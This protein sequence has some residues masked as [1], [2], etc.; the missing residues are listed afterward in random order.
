[1]NLALG[2]DTGGTYTDAVVI[3]FETGQVVESAKALTTRHD[4]SIGI[5]E[6]IQ[7]V[8]ATT[9]HTLPR[10]STEHIE[11]VAVSTTLATNS[12]AEGH[13]AKVTLILIGYDPKLM[14]QYGF[15][16]ELSTEDVVHVRG[17]HDLFGEEVAPL[18]EEAASAAV[19]ARL[20]Y[21]EAFAVS[22]YFGVRNPDHENRVR[23]IIHELT[24]RPVTCGHELTSHLNAVRRATTTT[25]NAHLIT[26]LAELISSLRQTLTAF[27][28]KAPLMVVK[29][30]G[31]LVRAEWATHRPIETILSGPA[32]SIV[33][34]WHLAGKQDVWVVDVGGTTTDIGVL[35]GGAPLLSK[36]G[37]H[38]AGW[39]TMI[40]AIDV[41]TVGLG[42]D[43]HVRLQRGR[44][45]AVGPRR[46][47]PLCLLGAQ[48]PE[49]V[50]ELCR[51]NSMRPDRLAEDA[52]EFLVPGRVAAS[53]LGDMEAEI[54]RSLALG[55]QPI[56]A[57]LAKS[58]LRGLLRHAIQNLETL[59]LARRA[60]FTPTDAL[61]SLGRF[62]RWNTEAAQLGAELLATRVGISTEEFCERV[63]DGVANRI[64]TELVTTALAGEVG[65]P[66]WDNEP[67]ARA[68]VRR[69]FDD[70]EESDLQCRITLRR[71]LVAIG[72]PV[73]A[74]MPGVAKRLNTDVLIPPHADVAN[75]V[76][77]VTGSVV[78][79][80]EAQISPLGEG[81]Q[82]RV[83]L[84]GGIQD[85]ATLE[86]AVTHTQRAML[87]HVEQLAIQA[88]G[89]QI[90]T[91]V[92]RK[93]IWIP[94]HDS[95]SQTL[96]LGSELSFTAIGRPSPARH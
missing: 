57:L 11:L 76:G 71:P 61:H 49:V 60:A 59:G 23:A 55:P 28:I 87:A 19:R 62:R 2:I 69:A 58:R 77:A 86:D 36:N 17:G 18:D 24:D 75:A 68:L 10:F 74:Y 37:A 35:R 31:S 84:P 70:Y 40:E 72:A 96:Y 91:R 41:H 95:S 39:Q 82:L 78:Q 13:R 12:L 46:V 9:T 34:A 48:Y 81:D 25:L 21:V 7:A 63:I 66:T 33:G 73:S 94:V 30:D 92:T 53:P 26:P 27:S 56:E 29:G 45:L 80:A 15:D 88:G 90:E 83:Y 47:V 93:D 52:G 67:A 42:G 89:E 64:A 8:L 32:A 44:E 20:D 85:F 16:R 51:L 79:R 50:Q 38:L 4:L 22:G 1:V 3:N 65:L 6:A 54:L 14:A 5:G 43:S